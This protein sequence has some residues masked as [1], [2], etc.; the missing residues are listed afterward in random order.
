MDYKDFQFDAIDPATGQTGV[1]NISNATIKGIEFQAQAKFGGLSFDGGFAYVDSK[2]R[3]GHHRQ[4]PRNCRQIGQLGPQCPTGTPSNPPAC[5][6]YG[7]YIGPAGGGPN[8]FS[9]KWSYN[10]GR[11]I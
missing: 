10:L 6:D 8:L 4:C 2:S 11:A 9:P 7:P 3:P 1:V 5:F